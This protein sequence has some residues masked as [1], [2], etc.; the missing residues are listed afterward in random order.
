[1]IN[2][3]RLRDL[4]RHAVAEADRLLAVALNELERYDHVRGAPAEPAIAYTATREL[5]TIARQFTRAHASLV[6]RRD[7]RYG[8]AQAVLGYCDEADARGDLPPVTL[9]AAS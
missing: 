5:A 8:A 6:H 7:D 2:E 3:Q 4:H 1:M 9:G